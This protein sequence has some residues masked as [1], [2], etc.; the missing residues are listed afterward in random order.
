M[1][2][3]F[4][5]ESKSSTKSFQQRVLW[6]QLWLTLISCPFPPLLVGA[7]T[8][9]KECQHYGIT[10]VHLDLMPIPVHGSLRWLHCQ[11]MLLHMYTCLT[12]LNYIES[13]L[14]S[15]LQFHCL[16][17]MYPSHAN[18]WAIY[19]YTNGFL[20]EFLTPTR[21]SSNS[22][23]ALRKHCSKVYTKFPIAGFIIL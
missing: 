4:W 9:H 1:A 11:G 6:H 12:F 23:I 8:L 16:I 14:D 2:P 21:C 7:E 5:M 19:H 20:L 13:T 10:F 3:Y 17:E 15:S 18:L 22:C